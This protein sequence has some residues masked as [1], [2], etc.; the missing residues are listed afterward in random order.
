MRISPQSPSPAEASV[1]EARL[2]TLDAESAEEQAPQTSPGEIDARRAQQ[3]LERSAALAGRGDMGA[4]LLATRQSLALAP[5]NVE[6]HLLLA[7]LLERSRD[8]G[9]ARAAYEKIVQ[10]APQRADVRENL[11]RLNTYLE[12]SQGA[13]R[14]FQ[15]DSDELFGSEPKVSETVMIAPAAATAAEAS[16]A[17]ANLD[18]D[19]MDMLDQSMLPSIDARLPPTSLA[20][21]SLEMPSEMPIET[22]VAA[23]VAPAEQSED[24]RKNNVPVATE[25]RRAPARVAVPLV[26]AP[27]QAPIPLATAPIVA[28]IIAK[29]LT[30]RASDN[31]YDLDAG[32]NASVPPLTPRA[33]LDLDLPS[34][35]K[36]PLWQQ[37]TARPSFFA[38][39]LPVVAVALLS[40]GFLSW[41][42]GRAIS[43]VVA[44]D[45]T[46]LAQ[47]NSPG[48]QD[49]SMP[50]GTTNPGALAPANNAGIGSAPATDAAGVPISN[51]PATFT[52]PS[53]QNASGSAATGGNGGAG[54]NAFGATARASNRANNN[55][56]AFAPRRGFPSPRPVPSFPNV[57]LAPAP[58]P[59]ASV[60]DLSAGG[61]SGGGNIILPSPSIEMPSAP[62]QPQRVLPPT[63]NGLNPAGSPGRGYVRVTEGRV[64]AGVMPSQPGSVARE[65][66]NNANASARSGQTDQAISQLSQAIRADSDNAGFRYQQ[67]AMLFLQRGDYNRAT[68]DFQSAISA[69]QTQISSGNNVAQAKSGLN[70]A[71]SGL[72]LALAGKRG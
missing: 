42:R 65:N 27:I 37:V 13:A 47:T 57:S 6:G 44:P 7:R 19:S 41:A 71:R 25:R 66:E 51:A 60:R 1:D 45:P 48:A 64:G 31:I 61:Q 29:P 11:Q 63:D 17:D 59:P 34:G 24:R 18:D 35:A 36:T 12:Q 8:F 4:A 26:A 22:P 53:A 39:T 58:I 56:N 2:E 55:G 21:T 32:L 9:G 69:Y 3:L 14:Q 38:R 30:A 10:L 52:A 15:F 20:P 49:V 68:D 16:N 72:T 54:N 33:A 5:S 28:P 50:T 23:V 43:K 67:R 40:L 70:S 62:I 46:A